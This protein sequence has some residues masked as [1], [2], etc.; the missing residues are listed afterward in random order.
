MAAI[1]S[2]WRV[3]GEAM[4]EDWRHSRPGER[5]WGWWQFTARIEMPAG[6][7]DET[8]LLLGLG[9]MDTDEIEKVIAEGAEV[10]ADQEA[11]RVAHSSVPRQVANA[12]AALK[13]LGRPL[14]DETAFRR[15]WT[16]RT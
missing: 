9:A 2:Q 5:P 14:L 8:A 13:H 12:Q 11:G 15:K 7:T 4:V 1:E 3:E 6:R 10:I 16:E